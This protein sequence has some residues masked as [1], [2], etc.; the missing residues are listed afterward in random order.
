MFV[1]YLLQY[2]AT[3]ADKHRLATVTSR[4]QLIGELN[5]KLIHLTWVVQNSKMV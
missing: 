5:M 2:Q 3:L 1:W 4:L